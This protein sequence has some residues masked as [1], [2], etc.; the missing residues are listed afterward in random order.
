MRLLF[1]CLFLSFYSIGQNDTSSDERTISKNFISANI[2]TLIIAHNIGVVYERVLPN[3][4]YKEKERFNVNSTISL[5]LNRTHVEF[6]F[7]G[8]EIY[9]T[10]ISYISFGRIY[11]FKNTR[12]KTKI[13]LEWH[14]GIGGR[15]NLDSQVLRAEPV[16]KAGLRFQPKKNFFFKINWGSTELTGFGLGV[17]F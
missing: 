2:G 8:K 13:F 10:A 11:D 17:C 16:F 12:R 3:F 7:F 1:V 4:L 6:N 9:R 5:S 14:L 15:Y